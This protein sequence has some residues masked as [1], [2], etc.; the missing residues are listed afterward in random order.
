MSARFITAQ[1]PKHR[2]AACVAL[3]VLGGVVSGLGALTERAATAQPAEGDKGKAA[4]NDPNEIDKR[5][6]V[7]ANAPARK[8][9]ADFQIKGRDRAIFA[10]IEDF[11]PVASQAQNPREYD[12]WIEFVLHARSQST[13]EL[14]G[15]GI[16]DLVPLDFAKLPGAY[17]TE[18]IRFD[19]E[20]SCVRRL[21]SPPALRAS[22]IAELYEARLV[23]VDESPLTPVSIVFV[24]LPE[25]LG[26]VKNK[27]VEEWLDAA[28]WVSATGYFFK[29]MS[30][31]GAQANAVVHLPLLIGK[32]LV[33]LAGP[34]VGSPTPTA[35]DKSLRIYKFIRD[36]AKMARNR[37]T[38]TAWPEIAAYNRVILHASRF[39]AEEL[40][41]DASTDVR[42]ADLFEE[43]RVS[44]RLQ[45]V[46]FEG[47]LISLRQM[48]TNEWLAAAGV[49]QL[50][51]GWLIPDHEPRGNPVCVLFSEPPDGVEPTGRVNK[52][53]SFAGHFFKLMRYESA[54]VDASDP[55]KN[56]DKLAPLLIGKKPI[57][58]P[59]P[60]TVTSTFTWN[61]FINGAVIAGALLILS[62]GLFAWWY[63]RGDRK[64]RSEMATVRGRNPFD[65]SAAPPATE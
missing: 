44:Y 29:T 5:P 38:E 34:P 25:S 47:R 33:P 36:G 21:V 62:S 60:D 27:P 26:A 19:G 45:C 30:V 31:P 52:W 51:E 37:P 10:A 58:R 24:E 39:S 40:E 23:P 54:E 13:R 4:P 15:Y 48:K 35:L 43:T 57:G 16:R 28:G 32:G 11:K 53:V 7:P 6:P 18:L 49:T 41:R 59:D 1:P 20:L 61:A 2:F 63:R 22:G 65:P 14:S 46:K 17:R 56:V 64:T 12:A 42:F 50:Y 3:A 9:F 55:S 8:A